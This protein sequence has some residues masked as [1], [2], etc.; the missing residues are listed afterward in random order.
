MNDYFERVEA[1]LLDAVERRAEH[2]V[3]GYKQA[4]SV[5]RPRW[6]RRAMALALGGGA[7]LG[8]V[9]A[10]VLALSAST[11]PPAYALVLHRDGSLTLTVNEL[12][13][14]EPANARLAKLGVRLRL[15]KAEAGCSAKGR[16]VPPPG[17]LLPR[18]VRPE[19][20]GRGLRGLRMLVHP[21]A[22]PAGDTLVLVFHRIVAHSESRSIPG[23]AGSM[24]LYRDPAPTCVSGPI[25]THHNH[26]TREL[27]GAGRLARP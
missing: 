13:G 20:V 21:S 10:L 27:T 26:Y 15:A 22:I 5:T 14:I 1:H 4:G 3:G 9:I 19:K 7:S 16:P 24:G 11:S 8:T 25:V 6:G 12:V 18:L 17:L 23:I 2:N